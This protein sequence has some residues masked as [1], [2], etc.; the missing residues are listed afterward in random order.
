MR[1]PIMRDLRLNT[2][3]RLDQRNQKNG[4]SEEVSARGSMALSYNLNRSTYF[5]VELGGQL[6]DSSNP[7]V[8]TQERGLFG[9][10]GIRQ[11]F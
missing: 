10:I 7:L 6:S 5:D 1:Y 2:K 8:M 4:S 11:D 9:T 3:L